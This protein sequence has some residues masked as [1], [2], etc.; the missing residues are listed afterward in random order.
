MKILIDKMPES[1]DKCWYGM[2]C[3][4]RTSSFV[5]CKNTGRECM[6]TKTCLF[7]TDQIPPKEEEK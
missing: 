2:W 5:M 4:G 6:N 7:F 3:G 1:P